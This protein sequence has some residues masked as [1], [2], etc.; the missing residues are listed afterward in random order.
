[1]DAYAQLSE[2]LET[3]GLEAGL[4]FLNQRVDHRFTAVYRLEDN[5]LHNTA[6]ID[7][8]DDDFDRSALSAIPL[9]DSFCQ[10]VMRDGFFRTSQTTGM[11]MLNGHP[12]QGVLESYVGLPIMTSADKL[13]GTLCHFDFGQTP[14]PDE[15]FTFLQKV[16]RLLPRYIKVDPAPVKKTV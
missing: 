10:F 2:S 5:T 7:K 4:R 11:D 12:Y 9:G 15:E 13:Y 14:L 1:M 3:G 6:L 16:A 8:V